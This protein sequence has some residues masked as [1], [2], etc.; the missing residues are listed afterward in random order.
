ML[1]SVTGGVVRGRGAGGLTAAD[2]PT[3]YFRL[4][5]TATR[6]VELVRTRPRLNQL[7]GGGTLREVEVSSMDG[8]RGLRIRLAR[9]GRELPLFV[10]PDDGAQPA[11]MRHGGLALT[12][13]ARPEVLPRGDAELIA[14]VLKLVARIYARLADRGPAAP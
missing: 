9:S 4:D 13:N 3:L 12:L 10:Q 14:G 2:D 11:L 5:A 8:R 1:E 7:L 6:L